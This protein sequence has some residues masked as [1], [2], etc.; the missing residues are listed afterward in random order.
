MIDRYHRQRVL[1]E[2][3]DSGQTILRSSS[4]LMIG[5]GGLASPA[6]LYLAAAGIGRIGILDGDRISL[7]NLQRQILFQSSQAGSL[8]VE[9]ARDNLL[10]LNPEVEIEIHPTFLADETSASILSNYDVLIDG[11]DQYEAKALINALALKLKKPMIFAGVTAFDVQVSVFGLTPQAPCYRC[12]YPKPPVARIEN[13]EEA[14]VLGP[15]AGIAG[16][17][18]ALQSIYALLARS[19]PSH[20][21]LRPLSG[22]LLTLDARDLQVYTRTLS[23]HPT[24]PACSGLESPVFSEDGISFLNLEQYLKSKDHYQLIDVREV[25]EWQERHLPNSQSLPLSRIMNGIA[26]ADFGAEFGVEKPIA[27][28]CKSGVRARQAAAHLMKLNGSSNSRLKRIH[29]LTVGIDEVASR[30]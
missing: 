4:V 16:S 27:L 30:T 14:G 11:T 3:G 6:L 9:A 18:Q 1:S 17:L 26:D 7:S 15:V 8:K 29:V 25:S 21:A 19:G 28:V 24:C 5:C 12:L 2:I 10:R 20:P 22:K 13:C 23:K